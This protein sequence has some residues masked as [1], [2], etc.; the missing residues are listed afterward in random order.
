MTPAERVN[1]LSLL[2]KKGFSERESC[3]LLSVCRS[4]LFYQPRRNVEREQL[5]QI[6]REEALK[7]PTYGYR[8]L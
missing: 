3:E 7:H 5:T 6:I 8:A 2:E 4:R 1:Q